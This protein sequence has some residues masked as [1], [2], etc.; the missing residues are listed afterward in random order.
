[1]ADPKG[2]PAFL[3]F[4]IIIIALVH[5]KMYV[6]I[7]CFSFWRTLYLVYSCSL[8][9]RGALCISLLN[10]FSFRRC[11]LLIKSAGI[12][13]WKDAGR[14][15]MSVLDALI[16]D[17][18]FIPSEVFLSVANAVIRYRLR[19]IPFFIKPEHHWRNGFGQFIVWSRYIVVTLKIEIFNFIIQNNR[20]Y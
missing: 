11:L 5:K 1:M 9:I 8:Y 2:I 15:G 14:R 6:T 7:C 20:H 4:F 13:W 19:Q 12:F 3:I 18:I 17:I 16:H 10:S